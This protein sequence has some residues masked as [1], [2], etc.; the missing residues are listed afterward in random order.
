MFAVGW[1]CARNKGRTRK[2][3]AEGGVKSAEEEAEKEM[4][5]RRGEE[6]ETVRGGNGERCGG[7]AE[8][9]VDPEGLSFSEQT[10]IPFW[11]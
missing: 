11:V 8:E 9:E 1:R 2:G 3:E 7:E 5:T 6:G 10:I 4:V